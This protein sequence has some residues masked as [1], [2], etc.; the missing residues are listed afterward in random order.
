MTDNFIQLG[1]S[2]RGLVLNEYKGEY[3]IAEAREAQ[4]GKVW[5]DFCY[6]Q[7][8]QQP[9]DKAVPKAVKL[10]PPAQA[11]GILR[12]LLQQLEA[13]MANTNTPA[14]DASALGGRV[15]KPEDD[16]IGF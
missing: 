2:N 11:Y 12:Q 1:N 3:S 13:E 16:D 7:F 10:G 15:V 9:Q 5:M 14:S 8:K 6:P 4:D